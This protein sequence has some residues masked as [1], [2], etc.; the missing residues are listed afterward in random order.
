MRNVFGF[1]ERKP[2]VS[3]LDLDSFMPAGSYPPM[4]L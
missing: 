2:A 3:V 1:L 4:P